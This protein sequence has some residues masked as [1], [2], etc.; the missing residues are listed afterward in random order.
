MRTVKARR[1]I[2]Q[3]HAATCCGPHRRHRGTAIHRRPTSMPTLPSMSTAGGDAG[4]A[5]FLLAPLIL[6]RLLTLKQAAARAGKSTGTM[7]LWA[8]VYSIGRRIPRNGPWHISAPALENCSAATRGTSRLISPAT[9]VPPLQDS[10]RQAGVP[11]PK[12]RP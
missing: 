3:R 5:S 10:S 7:R 6:T 9:A 11:S 2:R 1:S 8:E 12:G 4:C